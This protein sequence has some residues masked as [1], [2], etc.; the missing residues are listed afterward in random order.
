M[1]HFLRQLDHENLCCS[2]ILTSII[3]ILKA[4]KSTDRITTAIFETL[5]VLFNGDVFQNFN[6]D[7]WKQSDELLVL[8]KLINFK[9]KDIKKLSGSIKL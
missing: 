9:S 7:F 4:K 6:Q 2:D 5:N 3:D 1:L 8:I